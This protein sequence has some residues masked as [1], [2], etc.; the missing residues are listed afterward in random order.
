MLYFHFNDFFFASWQVHVVG[1]HMKVGYVTKF[2][3]LTAVLV[4][5]QVT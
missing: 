4:G 5:T 1:L 2:E 3:L